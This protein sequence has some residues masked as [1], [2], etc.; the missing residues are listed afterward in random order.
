MDK[1]IIFF[2]HSIKDKE[3]LIKLKELL[4]EKTN[5]TIK[6][7]LSCDGQSLPFGKNWVFEIEQSLNKT[8][9]MFVFLSPNSVHSKWIYFESGFSYSKNIEVIPIGILG[10]DLNQ[11]PPPMSLLQG[12]N[13]KDKNGLNNL[14]SIFNTKFNFSH[15]LQFTEK[16]FIE[17]EGCSTDNLL[18]SINEIIDHIKIQLVPSFKINGK[19]INLK[20][21]AFNIFLKY[22]KEN[23]ID[24]SVWSNIINIPGLS[25]QTNKNYQPTG[26]DIL[27]DSIL[28]KENTK[29]LKDIL[30]IIYS[31]PL[32]VYH[33]FIFIKDHYE[34]E[35]FSYKISSRL[36]QYG[37]KL[38]NKREDLFNYKNIQFALED[39]SKRRTMSSGSENEYCIRIVYN[40][41]EIEHMPLDSLINIL[42]DTKLLILK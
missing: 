19:E 31:K 21:K 38:S 6:V 34:L 17:L 12:F 22:F 36:F 10:L 27:I 32:D 37:I 29:Y 28:L 2:S 26:F 40:I 8:N 5:N 18:W 35:E 9:I 11:I 30:K 33:L 20:S 14:I 13:I 23:N 1:P 4:L 24:Y 42:L 41:D 39:F 7:F 3:Y 15:K 25:I 16:E